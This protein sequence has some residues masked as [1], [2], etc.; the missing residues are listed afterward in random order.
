MRD[1]VSSWMFIATWDRMAFY[2]A[3]ITSIMNSFQVVMVTDGR[4]SFAIFNYGD[5][6][7]TTGTDNGGDANTG[8]G[9]TPAQV[10]FNAGDGVTF[11]SVP[12]S[13]TAAIVDI[14][15]TSNIGVPGRW[16]FRTDNSN[17]E[18]LECTTSGAFTT[19]TILALA[20]AINLTRGY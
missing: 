3:K 14:E 4:F 1:F 15:T 5:I 13:Q 6:N 19:F 18:G 9:G 10:G 7:W 11:Y 17:I 2:G 8:L 20:D 12:G 16:V